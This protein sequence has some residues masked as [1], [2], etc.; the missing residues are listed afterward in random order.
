MHTRGCDSLA[1][2]AEAPWLCFQRAGAKSLLGS[3]TAVLLRTFRSVETQNDATYNS[4]TF[5]AKIHP[6]PGT[7]SLR[8]QRLPEKE[9][10]GPSRSLAADRDFSSQ[11][12]AASTRD[13]MGRV[14]V[15]ESAGRRLNRGETWFR[16]S[17]T[18]VVLSRGPFPRLF[19][20]SFPP[21]LAHR[22][23]RYP[24]ALGNGC[25]SAACRVRRRH[26]FLICAAT[27]RLFSHF[28]RVDLPVSLSVRLHSGSNGRERRAD[29]AI[30]RT[31]AAVTPL[32]ATMTAEKRPVATW[33][34]FVR[35][36]V[37]AV[38]WHGPGHDIVT[39]NSCFE[40]L[41][42]ASG[43]AFTV[44]AFL[45]R[46]ERRRPKMRAEFL[47]APSSFHGVP[48]RPVRTDLLCP[49]PRKAAFQE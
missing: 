44:V 28:L 33:V 29:L 13:E 7:S 8:R 37:G 45:R 40:P 43:C 47:A 46:S 15:V 1:I 34:L 11:S 9:I 21:N 12:A 19:Q 36:S 16:T 31:A 26:D 5:N 2:D 20:P 22:G 3:P 6:P 17:L 23:L 32:L 30:L 48:W 49:S 27:S 35:P 38:A 25:C 42:R 4:A 10:S 18:S 39:Q 24:C 41:G 14:W